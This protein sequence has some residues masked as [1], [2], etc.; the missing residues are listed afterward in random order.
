[1]TRLV[2]VRADDNPNLQGPLPAS[3]GRLSSLQILSLTGTGLEGVVPVEMSSLSQLEEIYLYNNPGLV[4]SVPSE[5]GD[6][7]RNLKLFEVQMTG[8]S[9]AIPQSFCRVE[10]L[11][12]NCAAAEEGGTVLCDC[13]TACFS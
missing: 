13:C 12:A 10:T 11:E 3:I 9:G 6:G 7:L 5:L 2:D 1:M 8:I 4:G